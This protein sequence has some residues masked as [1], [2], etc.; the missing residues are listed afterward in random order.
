MFFLSFFKKEKALLTIIVSLGI[1]SLI[2]SVMINPIL[3]KLKSLNKTI[4]VNETKLDSNLKILKQKDIIQDEYE[5]Y[6]ELLRQENS[7]EQEMT[8][9]L[10]NI[11][12]AVRGVAL[13]ITAM[14]PKAI[15]KVDLYKR[16]SVDVE[17]E[18]ELSEMTKFIYNLENEPYLLRIGRLRLGRKS[19]RRSSLLKGYLSVSKDLIP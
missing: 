12:S 10:S 9:L 8:L 18:A 6:S 13:R 14:K 11:E 16:L 19:R 17:V 7:D 5:R 2:Y 1:L 15:K 4:L 3:M